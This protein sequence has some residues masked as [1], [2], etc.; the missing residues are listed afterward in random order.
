MTDYANQLISTPRSTPPCPPLS[1]SHFSLLTYLKINI[2]FNQ[3]KKQG[4]KKEV[5]STSLTVRV[6]PS[7]NP[8]RAVV[9]LD[10]NPWPTPGEAKRAAAG[11][12]ALVGTGAAKAADAVGVSRPYLAGSVIS[13]LHIRLYD[14]GGVEVAVGKDTFEVRTFMGIV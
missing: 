4:D 3:N 13:G 9:C 7:K 8:V 14:Q 1:F 11:A 6:K 2:F 10:G 5:A 12:A